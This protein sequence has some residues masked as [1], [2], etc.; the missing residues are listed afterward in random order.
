MARSRITPEQ[1]LESC[2]VLMAEGSTDAQRA[3][4]SLL[5]ASGEL[6]QAQMIAVFEQAQN[7]IIKEIARLKERDLVTFHVEAAL[8]RVHSI[9][10]EMTGKSEPLAHSLVV[11]RIIQGKITSRMKNRK[12]NYVSAFELVN[13][14][15]SNVER[16]V[17]QILGQITHAAGCTEQSVRAQVQSACV[18]ANTQAN[19]DVQIEV[20]FPSIS[21]IPNSS[22]KT[23]K[24]TKHISREK[25]KELERAPEKTAAEMVSDAYRQI[26]FMKNNYVLGRREADMI[27]RRTLQSVAATEASGAGL[28]NAEK[29]L[30]SSLLKDGLTAFVDRSGKRWSLGVYCNMAVRTTSRQSINLGRLYD[31]EDQD[32]YIIVNRHSNCPIC[33]RY[34]GRV[35]SRSGTNPNYPPL[36]A[37]FGKIDKSGDTKIENTYLTIH[38]NCRHTINAWNELAHTEKEVEEMR[39]KSNPQTNPFDIDPRTEKQIEL[40]KEREQIMAEEAASHRM[41]REMMQYIP[42]RELGTWPNFHEHYKANDSKYKDLLAKY[43]EK[44]KKLSENT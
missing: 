43:R 16:V 3:S 32:L 22:F 35:Y 28:V 20:N 27:R 41:Y 38:P 15:T 8:Q 7:D 39:R 36:A 29:S 1:M 17:N 25:Q 2:R 30:I 11:A 5:K 10:E 9:L 4:M 13:T 12:Q 18:M 21:T 23:K 19:S 26:A 31:D 14:D 33:S 6:A 44:V 24:V 42:I 40:Y 34:E 37:A